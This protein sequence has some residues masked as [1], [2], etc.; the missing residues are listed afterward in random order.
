[1]SPLL[2]IHH[3]LPP[4]GQWHALVVDAWHIYSQAYGGCCH[5]RELNLIITREKY[6]KWLG[7]TIETGLHKD[8]SPL[9]L[10]GDSSLPYFSNA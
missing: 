10:V 9:I 2:Y 5:T 1:M 4:T 8:L 6:L 3:N 7:L